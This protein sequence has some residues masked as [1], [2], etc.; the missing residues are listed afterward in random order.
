VIE[1]IKEVTPLLYHKVAYSKALL[2]TA[3]YYTDILWSIEDAK[4]KFKCT[5]KE[6]DYLLGQAL[7]NE[8]TMAQIW[9]AIDFH[10]EDNGL[11]K[12]KE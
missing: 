7:N 6:A 1:A 10:G 9:F 3:G 2:K 12:I 5:D 8:A 11:T 4:H